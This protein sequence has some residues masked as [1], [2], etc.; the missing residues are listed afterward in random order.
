MSSLDNSQPAPA[1][2]DEFCNLVKTKY[3]NLTLKEVTKEAKFYFNNVQLDSKTIESWLRDRS[4]KV[5]KKHSYDLQNVELI[6]QYSEQNPSKTHNDLQK[7]C[8]KVFGH[9]VEQSVIATW[10]SRRQINLRKTRATNS[11]GGPSTRKTSI[12]NIP[13]FPV[14]PTAGIV[15]PSKYSDA[16]TPNINIVYDPNDERLLHY[17]PG[18]KRVRNCSGGDPQTVILILRHVYSCL[19][20]HIIVN[21]NDVKNYL[22]SVHGVIKKTEQINTLF[23]RYTITHRLKDVKLKKCTPQEFITY[24]RNTFPEIP[25]FGGQPIKMEPYQHQYNDMG[26]SFSFNQHRHSDTLIPSPVDPTTVL[27]LDLPADEG[28]IMSDFSQP[29]TP[30]Q[31]DMINTTIVSPMY[32]NDSLE[33]AAHLGYSRNSS[34]SAPSGTSNVESFHP[35]Q[36][37]QSYA[38]ES[39][40]AVMKEEY[41]YF[42]RGHSHRHVQQYLHQQHQQQQQQQ[43]PS[44]NI[45]TFLLGDFHNIQQ[46]HQV[47]Q[48]E[49][50]NLPLMLPL[51]TPQFDMKPQEGFSLDQYHV[52]QAMESQ[53]R[54]QQQ[55]QQQQH[56][57]QQ[58]H[59]QSNYRQFQQHGQPR[60]SFFHSESGNIDPT[61]CSL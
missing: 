52:H 13:M 40:Q 43:Q 38:P 42:N 32:S 50:M 30:E 24:L 9:K 61:I 22:E 51:P 48:H 11:K 26:D 18:F 46:N 12:G 21:E 35:Y 49:K 15:S 3:S 34:N 55:Q 7:L 25:E 17:A 27:A 14:K 54:Q 20:N 4:I 56:Q 28:S 60:P 36:L 33:S 45:N 47:H 31:V 59:K 8:E 19:L 37:P 1:A 39:N 6:C 29:T 53:M 23:R 57:Y 16:Q 44:M 10:L 58:Q 2:I 41:D 5:R